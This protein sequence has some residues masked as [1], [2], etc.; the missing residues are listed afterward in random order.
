MAKNAN[1]INAK[2]EKNDEFFTQFEDITKELCHK[3]YKEA[4]K[5]KKIYCPFS[6]PL[7]PYFSQFY[8]FFKLNFHHLGIESLL[9]TY[10]VPDG[11][12]CMAYFINGD[13]NGN[14]VIDD[15]DIELHELEGNGDFFSDEIQKLVDWADVIV[16]NVPFSRFREIVDILM[17][18]GKQF[19]I[20]GNNNAI[21]YKEI[22]PYLKDNKMFIGYSYPK[23]FRLP[24]N[25]TQK[26]GNI[27]WF[28][29]IPLDKHKAPMLFGKT[30]VGN[31]GDYPKYDNYDAINVD[32]VC[33][34]PGDYWGVMGVPITFMNNIC[35]YQWSVIG[36][37]HDLKGDGG[38]SS[39]NEFKINGGANLREFS[40]SGYFRI[41]GLSA[42]AGYDE[43]I[44]GIPFLGDKDA[45]ATIN[46]KQVYARIFIQRIK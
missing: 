6:S 10:L 11:Q 15:N 20:I 32:R 27:S 26:F 7:A 38:S 24:D 8:E 5:G 14:G 28:T 46:N 17:K 36:H 43:S 44:V 12:K 22:F 31:E 45:K 2:K 30:Y 4:F 9:C 16:D 40:S 42:S 33:D 41:I 18:K 29:N 37:E 3:E 21:T 23:E 25:T 39:I 13:K 35:T 34:I 19:A 1:M